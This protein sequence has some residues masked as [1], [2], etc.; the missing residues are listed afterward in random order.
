MEFTSEQLSVISDALHNE[1]EYG[2]L[3]DVERDAIRNLCRKIDPV[4]RLDD[5]VHYILEKLGTVKPKE[6]VYIDD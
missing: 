5:E 3:Y 2:H 1:L 4:L 6:P